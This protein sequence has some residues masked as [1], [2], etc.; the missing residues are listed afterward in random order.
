M[1]RGAGNIG[2][3]VLHEAAKT[4]AFKY[5]P[6]ALKDTALQLKLKANKTIQEFIDEYYDL[7]GEKEARREYEIADHKERDLKKL[8]RAA[9][10]EDKEAADAAYNAAADEADASFIRLSKIHKDAIIYAK[11]KVAGGRRRT[12]KVHNRKRKTHRKH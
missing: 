12:R 8:A 4:P 5:A 3:M 7:H 10:P 2:S 1:P 9:K 6:K 11:S